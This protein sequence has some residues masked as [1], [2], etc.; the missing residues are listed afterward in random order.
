MNEPETFVPPDLYDLVKNNL[1]CILTKK[2]TKITN[3]T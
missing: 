3:E 1:K 2:R